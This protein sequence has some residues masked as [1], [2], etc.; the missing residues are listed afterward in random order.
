MYRSTQSAP[1]RWAPRPESFWNWYCWALVSAIDV[2]RKRRERTIRRRWRRRWQTWCRWRS[3]QNQRRLPRVQTQLSDNGWDIL[4]CLT[5][6]TLG[7]IWVCSWCW[8]YQVYWV[9]IPL[10]KCMSERRENSCS[11]LNRPL[12]PRNPHQNAV[13][14]LSCWRVAYLDCMKAH[15]QHILTRHAVISCTHIVLHGRRKVALVVKVVAQSDM[16]H[17]DV[18]LG[19]ACFGCFQF[20][21]QTVCWC[22]VLSLHLIDPVLVNGHCRLSFAAQDFVQTLDCMCVFGCVAC[23]FLDVLNGCLVGFNGQALA[24]FSNVQASTDTGIACVRHQYTALH[25]S[26]CTKHTFVVVDVCLKVES[27]WYIH[28]RFLHLFAPFC[29]KNTVKKRKSDCISFNHCSPYKHTHW[30]MQITVPHPSP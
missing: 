18:L 17:A 22:F 30:L 4:I 15:V 6:I 21:L 3:W 14:T 9:W 23:V 11:R 16:A 7:S 10:E 19:K 1:I 28:A 26:L 29:Y 2:D 8:F 24:M 12:S 20:I 5:R 27:L 13:C 25:L